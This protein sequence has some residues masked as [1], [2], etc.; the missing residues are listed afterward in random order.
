MN[1]L[2]LLIAVVL[3]WVAVVVGTWQRFFQMPKWFADPPASFT[4]IRKQSKKAKMFWIPLS[5][6]FILFAGAALI[7]NWQYI[8]VRNYIM[9]GLASYALTGILSGMYFV[10]EVIAFTKIPPDAPKTQELLWR[11]ETWLRWT[12]IRDVLQLFAAIFLTLAY[13]NLV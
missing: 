5:A 9:L 12:T 1:T 8:Q 6:L 7:F 10:R 2:Y 3:I 13:K 11:T 4:L